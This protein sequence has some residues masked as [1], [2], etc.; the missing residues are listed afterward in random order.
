MTIRSKI[1][2][3]K[4]LI[5]TLG[6]KDIS[7]NMNNLPCN[8]TV[9]PFTDLNH[10]PIV[11]GDIDII[12]NNKLRKILWKSPKYREP[13]TIDFSNCKTEIKNI[14]IKFSSDWCYKKAVPVKC[15]TQWIS[16]VME[17]VNK[18]IKEL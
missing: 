11:T 6:T 2:N 8:C 14:L 5:K 1:F 15:F 12:Q 13:V 4:E 10:G 17:K 9:S 16:L 3:H 18:R 7:G